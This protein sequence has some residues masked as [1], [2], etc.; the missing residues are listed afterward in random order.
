V[1]AEYHKSPLVKHEHTSQEHARPE[2]ATLAEHHAE[3]LAARAVDPSGAEAGMFW[4]A[5]RPSEIPSAFSEYQRRCGCTLIAEFPSP[6]GV[7]TGLQKR[8]DWPR[9]DR[10]GKTPKWVSPP[11]GRARMVLA[12]VPA[13]LDEVRNGDSP[14]WS[15]EGLTRAAALA[16]LGIPAV[17]YA[18]CWNWQKDGEPLPCWHHV[19]LRGRRVLVAMDG[20]WRTNERVQEA[21]EAHVAFLESRGARVLVVSVPDGLGLDDATARGANPHVLAL[22]AQP[23]KRT[24]VS[25]ERLRRDE[26]LRRFVVEK[27]REVGEL[28]ARKGAECNAR[29]V[30]R[31]MVGVVPRHGKP[32]ER[33]VIVHPSF[34]QIAEG[35]RLG[36]FGTVRKALDRLEQLGFLERLGRSSPKDATSYR[37][38]DPWEGG[39]A[40]SVNIGERGAEG[41][42]GQEVRGEKDENPRTSLYQRES[43]LCL[44]SVHIPEMPPLRNSKLVHTY[45]RKGA[46][47]VVVDSEYF[48]RYGAKSEEIC[49][50]VLERGGAEREDLWH[51]FGSKTSRLGRFLETWVEPMLKDGVVV[52]DGSRILPAPNWVDALERVKA[53]T[54]EDTDNHLQSEKYRER[55]RKYRERLAGEKSGKVAKPERTP[56]LKGK[57]HTRE[58]IERN[59]PEWRRQRLE[60]EREKV[61]PAVAFVRRTLAPLKYIRL[62]L[63]EDMWQERGGQK[64]HLRLA[65]GEMRCKMIGHAE[66]P[67]ELF[68]YP[69]AVAGD[70][71][72]KQDRPPSNVI[73]LL[74]PDYSG[75]T[76]NSRTKKTDGVLVHEALCE[77]EW[78][79]HTLP[80]RY[81]TPSTG[82]VDE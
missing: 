11:A 15:V 26:R 22:K 30:A 44:H 40:Q 50:Y 37:L 67:G 78:C 59:T 46:R 36:S 38:L 72:A 42:E 47:R 16:P 62:G 2:G 66:H 3:Y 20:D 45:I 70:E 29:K 33:G 9:R 68:V 51:K 1:E 43:S 14:L 54:D 5:R 56:E 31:F 13:M 48:R 53:R 28:P 76:I 81:A 8:D 12:V 41:R 4:T 24:D 80:P 55:R 23:F 58:A 64:H 79:V 49:R 60:A 71:G 74:R 34:P 25:R 52:E 77:C 57:E 32:D 82:G 18:G 65:V 17:A 19:N 27:Q 73:P 21:L 35:T 75:E 7:T 69:P 61:E 10:K 63:L 6:D 39:S